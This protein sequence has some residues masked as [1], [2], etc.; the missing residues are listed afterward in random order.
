MSD[1]QRASLPSYPSLSDGDTPVQTVLV[2]GQKTSDHSP[3][4]DAEGKTFHHS[5]NFDRRKARGAEASPNETTPGSHLGAV[6]EE[7][8]GAGL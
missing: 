8:R 2:F 4:D 6:K 5:R 3:Q 1:P 7:D